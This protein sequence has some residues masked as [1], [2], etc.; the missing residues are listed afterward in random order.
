MFGKVIDIVNEDG[1]EI[2]DPENLPQTVVVEFENAENKVSI[3][4]EQEQHK[5]KMH[6]NYFEN[7]TLKEREEGGDRQPCRWDICG[8]EDVLETI[9]NHAQLTIYMKSSVEENEY[10]SKVTSVYYQGQKVVTCD[11]GKLCLE[12][13]TEFRDIRMPGRFEKSKNFH[14]QK[15]FDMKDIQTIET[16]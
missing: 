4:S 3:S 10:Y 9:G 11:K 15:T 16:K 1:S 5:W 6:N 14:T 8:D 12:K 13:V 7:V 2:E